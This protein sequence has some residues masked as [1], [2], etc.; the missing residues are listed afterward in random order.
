MS[1][2]MPTKT[3]QHSLLDKFEGE[4]RAE[5]TIWFGPDQSS[6]SS[7]TMKNSFVLGG[8][9]LKQDYVGDPA[10]ETNAFPGFAG[11]G[12]WGYNT[13][14][15]QYEGFWIDNASTAMQLQMGSVDE[16]GTVWT[17]LSKFIAPPNGVEMD[18]R[19]VITLIDD[20]HHTMENFITTPSGEEFKNMEIR[21]QRTAE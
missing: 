1:H 20:N 10:D 18:R 5:V 9:Y 2:G 16:S 17:M 19:S 13:T 6:S 21:Y 8:L 14:S 4:F 7:G 11:Q 12:Y 15:Q 3:D